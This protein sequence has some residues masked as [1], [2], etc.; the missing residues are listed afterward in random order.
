MLI[1]SRFMQAEEKSVGSRHVAS[2][3]RRMFKKFSASLLQFIY[4]AWRIIIIMSN[5]NGSGLFGPRKKQNTAK[6]V[7]G[8]SR[9]NLHMCM[10]TYADCDEVTD[11]YCGFNRRRAT[12]AGVTLSLLN[13]NTLR[14]GVQSTRVSLR[15]E[16]NPSATTLLVRS[17]FPTPTPSAVPAMHHVDWTMRTSKPTH[18]TA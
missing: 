4:G 16:L 2:C 6:V 18:R 1:F 17:C 11:P 14:R 10:R 5:A 3:L 12:C 13:K 15:S 7:S 9:C 8:N